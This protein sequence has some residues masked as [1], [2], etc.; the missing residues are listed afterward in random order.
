MARK[1][2]SDDKRLHFQTDRFVHQNGEWFYM[3]RGGEQRGPFLSKELAEA[4]LISHARH[5]RNME[6]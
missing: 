2:D 4:D 3:M 6:E 1:T 5:L